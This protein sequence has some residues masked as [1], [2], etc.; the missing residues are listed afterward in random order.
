MN[1][2]FKK[3]WEQ[4]TAEVGSADLE[5][6]TLEKEIERFAQLLIIECAKGVRARGRLEEDREP[7]IMYSEMIKRHFG[8]E[9]K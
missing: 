4:A 2:Y 1:A 6:V 5:A 8:V 7:S 9:E 3:I